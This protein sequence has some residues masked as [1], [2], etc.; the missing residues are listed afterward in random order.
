MIDLPK[1]SNEELVEGL[2]EYQKEIIY[3]LLENNNADQCLELWLNANGL[4]NNSNFGGTN[5]N[6]RLIKN[7][8]I[9]ICKLLSGFPEYETQVKEIK[10]YAN[11]GKDALISGLT[12]ALAPKL[13]TTAI[14]LVPLVVLALISISKVGVRAYCNSILNNN[15]KEE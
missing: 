12:L 13:G 9:E 3:Q 10:V 14:I 4:I 5:E 11:L 6:D 1:Y 15:E 8:K 2:K 7:F